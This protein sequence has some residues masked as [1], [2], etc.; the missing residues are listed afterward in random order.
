MKGCLSDIFRISC[1]YMLRVFIDKNRNRNSMRLC[2]NEGKHEPKYLHN[3]KHLHRICPR[4]I[5]SYYMYLR[6]SYKKIDDNEV[7][8]VSNGQKYTFSLIMIPIQRYSIL[9]I[10][11]AIFNISIRAILYVNNH[12]AFGTSFENGKFRTRRTIP[13]DHFYLKMGV[14]MFT[15]WN[16]LQWFHHEW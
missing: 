2:I 7:I 16:V 15:L 11:Y 1:T 9:D 3:I 4:N 6:G 8:V 10:F 13:V 14:C 5:V 12:S